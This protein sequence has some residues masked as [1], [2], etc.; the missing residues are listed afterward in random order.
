MDIV[1]DNIVFQLQDAGG[2]SS[3]W[4]QLISRLLRDKVDVKFVHSISQ[5]IAARELEINSDK[6]LRNVK[7]PIFLER[8]IN[9]ALKEL[10]SQFLFHSSYNR[11]SSNKR[12]LNIITVHDFIHEK[13]YH[14]FRKKI[15]CFQKNQAIDASRKIITVS[16]NT[17]NDLLN[18]HPNLQSEHVKV[19]YNGVSEEFYP[20]SQTEHINKPY[21]VFIGSRQPY[22]NFKF[23]VQLIAESKE[24]D[25]YIVGS[26]F[27][28]EEENLLRKISGRFKLF[29]GINNA[30]LNLLYNNAIVLIYPSSYEGFG[31]P[32]LEAMKAGLPFIAHNSSSI[33]E[34][35]G[36][37]GVLLEEMDI[38]AAKEALLKIQSNRPKYI[39]LGF[40]QAEKFSWE[41]CYQSTMQ[42]YK[43]VISE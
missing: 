35:A 39:T 20:V 7:S 38:G 21:L 30:Q 12:A 34:V 27:T 5:N 8:F 28:S 13:F 2:I 11:I 1:Y 41:K 36:N 23:A 14:G 18:F 15:H 37:A 10:T 43:E 9:P 16:E 26:R 40:K 22:K 25:L 24:F 32:V 29:T 6:I 3:Y 17:K 31:L 42:L 19:I 33:P 4:L